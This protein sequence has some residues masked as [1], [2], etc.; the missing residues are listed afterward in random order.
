MV[1]IKL[2]PRSGFVALRQLNP[3]QKKGVIKLKF[4]MLRFSFAAN[5]FLYLYTHIRFMVNKPNFHF[6]R[7]SRISTDGFN[8][9]NL[10][11]L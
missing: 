1:K 3:I 2:S 9:I 7:K 8:K 5:D 10:S 6:K 11:I 4:F